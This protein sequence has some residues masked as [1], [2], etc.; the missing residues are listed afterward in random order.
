MTR[1]IRSQLLI[2]II[3][4]VVLFGAII[5]SYIWTDT[6]RSINEMFDMRLQRETQ[7]FVVIAREE[8][9][10]TTQTRGVI[11]WPLESDDYENTITYQADMAMQVWISGKMRALTEGTP[12]FPDP[13]SPGFINMELNEDEWR[14]FYYTETFPAAV[15][16]PVDIWVAIGEPVAQRRA[17]I[18]RMLLQSSLPL[19]GIILLL[20]AVLFWGIGRALKPLHKLKNQIVRRSPRSL[21]PVASAE[22]PQELK[23]IVAALNDLLSQLS[24]ALEKEKRFT[25]DAAHELRTPLSALMAQ[26]QVAIREP[27]EELRNNALQKLIQGVGRASHLVNQLLTLSRL[28]PE[29]AGFD[30]LEFR[31]APVMENLLAD[32]APEALRRNID[33]RLEDH[34]GNAVVQGEKVL[35]ETLL[36]NIVH[37]AI[38][39]A[40]ENDGLVTV[41]INND[42]GDCRI[43]VTDNG[44]GIPL[45]DIDRVFDRFYRIPGNS[46]F[47][48]G[49]GLSIA[50]RIARLHHA[51]LKLSANPDDTGLVASISLHRVGGAD[52]AED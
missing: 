49:L 20:M 13:T 5:V 4:T 11:P 46:S 2:I 39:Y 7:M 12:G 48:A 30:K 24:I 43:I 10:Q 52:S 51:D 17:V 36:R 15:G 21:R 37:N 1:S 23:P 44:P 27:D 28:D 34:A 29:H 31:L 32:L 18:N 19:I 9:H 14:V 40:P 25:A 26:A 45:E 41:S 42:G 6:D 38:I 33:L 16:D 3:G 35:I 50:S 47:G 22:T 8:H